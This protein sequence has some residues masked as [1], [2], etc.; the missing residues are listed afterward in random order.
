MQ[1]KTFAVPIIGGAAAETELNKFLRGQKVLQV[2]KQLVCSPQGNYWCFC[3]EYA[4]GALPKVPSA[5]DRKRKDY[6]EGLDPVQL[7]R[8]ERMRAIRKQLAQAE[9]IPAYAVFTD[10]ELAGL[11]KLEVVSAKTVRSVPGI[12]AKKL[13]KYGHHF[14]AN[15]PTQEDEKAD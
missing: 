9:S 1:I 13:E 4:A 14:F 7:E 15:T 11:A 10:K 3:V 8:F 2:L 5:S 6:R 12:G